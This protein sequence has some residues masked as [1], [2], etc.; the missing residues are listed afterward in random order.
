MFVDKIASLSDIRF[1]VVEPP[2]RYV[3]VRIKFFIQSYELPVSLSYG[4]VVD[5]QSGD[6]ESALRLGKPAAVLPT[7]PLVRFGCVF[8][9]SHNLLIS[10]QGGGGRGGPALGYIYTL[11]TP[12]KYCSLSGGLRGKV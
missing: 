10:K 12:E 6:Y 5:V 2:G 4:G 9:S 3:I 7:E 8:S 11:T 1:Q